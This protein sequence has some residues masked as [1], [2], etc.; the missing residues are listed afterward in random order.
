MWR[1]IWDT[2]R[3]G[4]KE[5]VPRKAAAHLPGKGCTQRKL[6]AREGSL[7]L[8]PGGI[9]IQREEQPDEQEKRE[10]QSGSH[11]LDL[12][13]VFANIKKGMTFPGPGCISG[14]L[15]ILSRQATVFLE[16]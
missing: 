1:A 8:S 15:E 7:P 16:K 4:G 11:D 10:D 9:V 5:T 6:T 3:S 13:I 14:G 2:R 12:C